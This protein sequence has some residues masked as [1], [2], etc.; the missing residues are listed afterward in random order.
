[1]ITC[2]KIPKCDW[3]LLKC[4]CTTQLRSNNC[5]WTALFPFNWK[6]DE[7]EFLAQATSSWGMLPGGEAGFS[8]V[9]QP[10]G[11]D[12][13]GLGQKEGPKTAWGAA[14]PA[15]FSIRAEPCANQPSATKIPAPRYPSRKQQVNITDGTV[16]LP[17]CVCVCNA[18]LNK[19]EHWLCTG[20]HSLLQSIGDWTGLGQ[21]SSSQQSLSSHIAHQQGAEVLHWNCF[22]I[23]K[24]LCKPSW[25]ARS[26]NRKCMMLPN[27]G[28]GLP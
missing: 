21:C 10:W 1:M 8:A 25:N 17:R 11:R 28:H 18:E 5:S 22:S 3:C 9:P 14:Y 20:S 6:L 12:M 19:G 13:G 26:A 2:K 24:S 7:Q 15:A 4:G 23:L 27:T 16:F